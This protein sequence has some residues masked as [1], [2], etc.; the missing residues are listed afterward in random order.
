MRALTETSAAAETAAADIKPSRR[1]GTPRRGVGT[2]H[3]R[4]DFL[5]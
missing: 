5:A 4:A 1:R 2:F 3:P